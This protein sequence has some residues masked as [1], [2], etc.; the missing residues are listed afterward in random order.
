MEPRPAPWRAP[1]TRG[2]RGPPR[3]LADGGLPPRRPRQEYRLSRALV[4]VGGYDFIG[5]YFWP[6]PC[7][8]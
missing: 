2:R 4:G 8:R 5:Y 3:G 7:G 1:P 6:L